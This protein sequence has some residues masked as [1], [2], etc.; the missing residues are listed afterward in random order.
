MFFKMGLRKYMFSY[1]QVVSLTK[2]A[3]GILLVIF[4][5]KISRKFLS[6]GIF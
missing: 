2:G 6:M 5:N 1:A 4:A 3:I